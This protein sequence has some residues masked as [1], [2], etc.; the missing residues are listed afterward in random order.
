MRRRG[1]GRFSLALAGCL[2]LGDLAFSR[3][4]EL[5]AGVADGWGVVPAVLLLGFGLA[6]LFTVVHDGPRSLRG[7][8]QSHPRRRNMV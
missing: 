2:I 4:I 6:L 1:T 5:G 7:L 3:A 8:L